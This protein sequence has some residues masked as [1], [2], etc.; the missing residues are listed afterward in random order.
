MVRREAVPPILRTPEWGCTSFDIHGSSGDFFLVDAILPLITTV[1]E[2]I[3]VGTSTF[4]GPIRSMSIF[5]ASRRAAIA[6]GSEIVLTKVLFNPPQLS[7][8]R[9]PLPK[10]PSASQFS[11]KLSEPIATSLHFFGNKDHLLVTYATHG[12]MYVITLVRSTNL[13]HNQSLGHFFHDSRPKHYPKDVHNVRGVAVMRYLLETDTPAEGDRSSIGKT[14]YW[15][16]RTSSM[17]WTGILCLNIP[18]YPPPNLSMHKNCPT[19][20]HLPFSR[21]IK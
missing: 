17:A 1:Q 8:E 13:S 9:K 10:P 19:P 3:V 20:R 7:D 12:I 11:T 16:Y 5:P 2:R 4:N 14:P 6:Y 21:V 15:R 18:S